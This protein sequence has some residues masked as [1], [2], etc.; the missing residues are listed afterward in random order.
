M[1]KAETGGTGQRVAP[2]LIGMWLAASYLS[3]VPVDIVPG[4]VAVGE[5]EHD[6]GVQPGS[7]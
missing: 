7:Y 2:R 1:C 3:L 6:G 5:A 4:F